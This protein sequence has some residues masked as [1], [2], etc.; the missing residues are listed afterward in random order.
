MNGYWAVHSNIFSGYIYMRDFDM[1][2]SK[3]IIHIILLFV[4]IG[5]ISILYYVEEKNR[6]MLPDNL[7]LEYAPLTVRV[8]NKDVQDEVRYELQK[9]AEEKEVTKRGAET[10]DILYIEYT[11]YVKGRPYKGLQNIETDF[12]LGSNTFLEDFEK[13]FIGVYPFTKI[14]FEMLFPEDY[15]DVP[16]RNQ[17][18]FF[19]VSIYR[20]IE[21]VFPRLTDSFVNQNFDCDN[22]QEYLDIVANKVYTLKYNMLLDDLQNALLSQIVESS[23]FNMSYY[24]PMIAKRIHEVLQSYNEY[25]KLSKC[26]IADV[27]QWF[28]TSEDILIETATYDQKKYEVCK[29]IIKEKSYCQQ[30][31]NTKDCAMIL[32]NSVDIIL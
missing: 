10:G 27:Y 28:D 29:K 13:N 19:E 4:C 18:V 3:R 23:S 30:Q 8:S 22:I 25:A 16:L 32:R 15:Y 20:I 14:S 11:G 1:R 26:S 31:M 17:K 7:Q 2:Y 21:V 12:E 24:K 5:V 9:F 6:I